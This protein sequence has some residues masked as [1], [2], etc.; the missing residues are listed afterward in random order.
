V[1]GRQKTAAQQQLSIGKGYQ[2][3]QNDIRNAEQCVRQ[4]T[5]HSRDRQILFST[6]SSHDSFLVTSVSAIAIMC[7]QS[8]QTQSMLNTKQ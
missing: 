5:S 7:I 8:N 3:M 6:D 1:W 2:M 4:Q